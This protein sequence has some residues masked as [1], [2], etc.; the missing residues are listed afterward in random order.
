[1]SLFQQG[2]RGKIS[3]LNSKENERGVGERSISLNYGM[4][5]THHDDVCLTCGSEIA[6]Y[7]SSIRIQGILSH[8][9][10]RPVTPNLTKT[11]NIC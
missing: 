6:Q 4:I 11:Y 5:V 9:Q 3:Y 1:M 2:E 7:P 8:K 10:V